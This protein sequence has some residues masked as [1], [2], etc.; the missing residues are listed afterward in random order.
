MEAS[1]RNVLSAFDVAFLAEL[2]GDPGIEIRK[3]ILERLAQYQPSGLQLN[4]DEDKLMH[5]W[6][7]TPDAW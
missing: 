3:L 5:C 2:T 6:A 7:R 4:G 1:H